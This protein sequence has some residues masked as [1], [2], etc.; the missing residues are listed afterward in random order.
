MSVDAQDIN[1]ISEEIEEVFYLSAE[2]WVAITFL[3][4][5]ILLYSPVTKVVKD[6]IA[7]RINRIKQE[8]NDAE[9]IKLEAQKLYADTERKLINIDKETEDII[10]NKKYLIEQTKE[11]KIHE[12]DYAMQRKKE[13]LEAKIEQSSLQMNKEINELIC[14]K[15]VD[16]LNKVIS[17]KLTKKEYSTLIDNSIEN[18]RHMKIG[19]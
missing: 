5:V 11:K 17:A 12:L 19:N 6:L 3:I 16:I 10:L 15:A 13:D 1:E 2:F 14:Q 4:V 7:K 8:L 18:I 9:N